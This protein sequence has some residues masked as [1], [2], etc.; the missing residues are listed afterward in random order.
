MDLPF[1]TPMSDVGPDS[2]VIESDKKLAPRSSNQFRVGP[3]FVSTTTVRPIY[4]ETLGAEMTPKISARLDRGF[5]LIEGQWIGY[6]RNYFTLVAAFCFSDLPLDICSTSALLYVAADDTHHPLLYFKLRLVSTCPEDAAT[7]V[8]LVQHTA[9]R[10]KGPQFS[11]PVYNAIPGKLPGHQVM[12]LVANI[13]NGDKI[14]RC[15]RL[16]NLPHLERRQLAASCGGECIL[17]TYPESKEVAL[18]ARYERIQFLSS[19]AGGRKQSST[20]NKYYTLEVQLLGVT[21]EDEVVLAYSQTPPLIVRGRSPS[22]YT[23][24]EKKK[25]PTVRNEENSRPQK[26]CMVKEEPRPVLGRNRNLENSFSAVSVDPELLN[27]TRKRKSASPP[28]RPVIC[29]DKENARER[30]P[31]YVIPQDLSLVPRPSLNSAA[32]SEG[33]DFP[34]VTYTSLSDKEPLNAPLINHNYKTDS[35]TVGKLEDALKKYEAAKGALEDLLH[36]S[37]AAGASWYLKLRIPLD[38]PGLH[39]SSTPLQIRHLLDIASTP[40]RKPKR[41]RL[42]PRCKHGFKPRPHIKQSPKN[43]SSADLCSEN[44]DSSFIL[45]KEKLNNFRSSVRLP[46]L[47]DKS[48]ILLSPLTTMNTEKEYEYMDWERSSFKAISRDGDQELLS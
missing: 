16:F 2:P 6:K 23:S 11:P 36:C 22:N 19:A 5:N 39:I 8:T 1:E 18:V 32:R 37:F 31:D 38:I 12:K 45:F 47:P 10:D 24:N 48:E 25:K 43:Y 46:G 34:D 33:L 21:S 44:Y 15:N 17:A 14:L 20:N 4:N 42:T 7:L 13:R 26:Q 3:P 35:S 40:C 41:T 27:S 28:H 29:S 9:K 30:L